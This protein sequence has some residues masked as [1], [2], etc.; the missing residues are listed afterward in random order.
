MPLRRAYTRNANTHNTNIV[1]LVPDH[2][3]LNA[4]FQNAIQLLARS[5]ANQNNQFRQDHKG[6]ASGSKSQG[7]TLGKR[8][9]PTCPKFGKNHPGECLEGKK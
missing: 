7:S 3:V 8:T 1:P 4:K 6:R 9:Y 2:E 5:V